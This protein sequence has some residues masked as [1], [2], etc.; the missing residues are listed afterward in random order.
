M[1]WSQV[2]VLAG[3]PN[4]TSQMEKLDKY[5]KIVDT[6]FGKIVVNIN[7]EYIG[8]SFLYKNYWAED[9]IMGISMVLKLKCKNKE[10]I[11]FYDIGS[12]IGSHSLALSNIFKDK[13]SIKA[14]EAQ[15][16]IYKMFKKTIE[17]NQIKNIK[18]YNNAVSNKNDELIRIE[19]PDYSKFNNF[20][21]FEFHK[22]YKN[23]TNLSIT[24]SG[25]YEDVKTIKLD[26]FDE[27]VDFIKMDIEGMENIAI[28]GSK[29][30][31]NKFRPILYIELLKANNEDIINFFKKN[32]YRIYLTSNNAYL[33]PNESTINFT[34][35][36]KL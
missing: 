28:D 3:P 6:K 25:I 13:I 14:F 8:K 31:I 1:Y 5:L 24:K 30:I 22:P 2:R 11:L 9:E 19:L 34:G 18:L 10:K 17:I 20:G 27:D 15:S 29:N 33:I 26:N 23:S 7:D 4:Y 36:K 16:N 35:L 12:N 32:D 21:A